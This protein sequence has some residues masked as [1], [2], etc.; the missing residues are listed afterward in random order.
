MNSPSIPI[1][2]PDTTS[3][4]VGSGNGRLYA[5]NGI[6]TGTP[7]TVFVQLGDG[8][9]GIGPPAVDVNNSLV[10]PGSEEG[11]VYAWNGPSSLELHDAGFLRKSR[12][13]K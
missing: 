3:A 4:L 11:V 7:T 8:L 1:H 12:I 6:H 9:S 5:I 2:I 10:L 13:F